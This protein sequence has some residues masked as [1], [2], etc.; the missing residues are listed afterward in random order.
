VVITIFANNVV[1]K[2]GTGLY[3]TTY[4]THGLGYID[5]GQQQLPALN[6]TTSG[7]LP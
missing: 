1:V 2:S 6:K 4:T 7:L 3:T 5:N